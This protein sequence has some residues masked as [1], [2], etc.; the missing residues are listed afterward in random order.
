[1]QIK[2][3][4]ELTEGEVLT[5]K[6]H[7]EQE[8]HYGFASDLMSDVLRLEA[9]KLVLLTGLA[10]TQALRTAEMSDINCIVFVRGKQID[11]AILE[12]ARENDMVLI[13]TRFSMFKTSAELYN[14]G[15]KPLF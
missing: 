4:I 6:S 15:L 3:L 10:N 9:D 11:E 5:G 8:V 14:A 12:L 13:R 1:M 2:K 7:L